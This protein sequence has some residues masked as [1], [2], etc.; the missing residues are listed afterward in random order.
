MKLRPS[1]KCQFVPA[2]PRLDLWS[3]FLDFGGPLHSQ[4]LSLR[5]HKHRALELVVMPG[6]WEMLGPSR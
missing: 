4:Y 1:A 5:T 3:M 2:A 6:R